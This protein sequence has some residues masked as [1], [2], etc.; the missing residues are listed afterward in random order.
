VADVALEQGKNFYSI[1]NNDILD[2]SINLY[3]NEVM[4]T[5]E[6]PLYL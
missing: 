4:K 3:L 6:K 2:L 5:H 1:N